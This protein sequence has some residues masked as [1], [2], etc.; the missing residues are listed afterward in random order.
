MKL[1]LAED[2]IDMNAVVKAVLEHE[3]YDVDSVFD[4][5]E[6]MEHLKSTG[7]DGIVLDIMIDSI[8]AHGLFL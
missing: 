8:T 4:G 1:L 5:E 7:Y 2:T 3:G 6:A